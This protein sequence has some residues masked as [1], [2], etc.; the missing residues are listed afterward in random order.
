MK[1]KFLASLFAAGLL[2]A[3]LPALCQ[4][5][6]TILQRVT[7]T[8]QGLKS[9]QAQTTIVE[10]RQAGGQRQSRSTTVTTRYKAPNKV[11]TVV[12]GAESV[13]IYSDGKNMYLYSPKDKE[14]VKMPAPASLAQT[15]GM[16]GLAVGDPA[17]IGNQLR[18]IFGN[19]GKKLADRTIG[20]KPAFVLQAVQSPQ[21]PNGAGEP[22]L[23]ATALIDKAT[24]M[25]RQLS[26]EIA[27]GQGNQRVQQ[28]IIITFNS[29]QI[30]PSLSDS[31]FVFRPPA[32]AKERQMPPPQQGGGA[33]TLPR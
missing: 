27:R 13:H 15:A 17:Q 8:Y 18:S 2:F 1:S 25:V 19:A 21:S 28:S 11:V 31:I 6:E 14:Y 9:Y 29:Q 33:P 22:R 7:N 26:L 23:T 12:Q 4:D 5:V 3:S 32:G 30:N 16:S 10:T 24:Y 20:G